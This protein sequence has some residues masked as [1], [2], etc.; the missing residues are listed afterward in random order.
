MNVTPPV[1]ILMCTLN[2]GPWL[3]EQ[4][5]SLL[6]QTYPHWRL[7]VSDD[8]SNDDTH[9][10]LEDFQKAHPHH[11]ER[12]L[13]GPRQGSAA[14]YLSLLCHPDLPAGPVALS[15]QDDVWFPEK[16]ARTVAALEGS[17]APRAYAAS[18]YITD[19]AL[20]HKKLA[21]AS[22]RAPT[23]GNALVQNIMSGH[24][25]ALNAAA[26]ETVRAAGQA[27][28]VHHDWWIYQLM[29]GTGTEIRMDAEPV[30][31]YRQ[32]AQNVFGTRTTWKASLKRLQFLGT[33]DYAGWISRNLDALDNARHL[34]TPEACRQLDRMRAT[35][36]TTGLAR[37]AALPSLSVTRQRR[38][39][40]ALIY[41]AAAFG[42]L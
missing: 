15:D 4:L 6:S 27:R 26:L 10:I 13:D 31:L 24:T 34:L 20:R 23:F 7:W 16:L 32:H 39:E 22:A 40:T 41:L 9:T 37:I 21:R 12:M 28:I 19:S 1:R 36:T 33:G 17:Q 38:A 14:N 18:Y 11:V 25:T 35:T 2:G 3:Q 30:L 29:T 5:E 8:G 42:R